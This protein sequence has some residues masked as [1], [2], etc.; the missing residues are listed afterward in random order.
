MEN[1]RVKDKKIYKNFFKLVYLSPFLMA[2]YLVLNLF[3]TAGRALVEVVMGFYSDKVLL[4]VYLFSL[5]YLAILL[6][7]LLLAVLYKLTRNEIKKEG[8]DR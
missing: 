2:S 6:F 1:S 7:S 5:F 4:T 3:Y 8:F